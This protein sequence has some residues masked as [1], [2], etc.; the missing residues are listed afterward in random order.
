MT[1]GPFSLVQTLASPNIV[2]T[3]NQKTM[4]ILHFHVKCVACHHNM[5]HTKLPMGM[6]MMWG[7]IAWMEESR[8]NDE[9]SGTGHHPYPSLFQRW[10][11]VWE[12]NIRR[13]SPIGSD[14]TGNLEGRGWGRGT[15][16]ATK[17]FSITYIRVVWDVIRTDPTR[18]AKPIWK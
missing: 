6:I 8:G 5:A 14:E 1:V 7:R 10:N 12:G 17:K 2:R 4:F 9:A 18:V 13:V 3:Y 16:N 15:G 11:D